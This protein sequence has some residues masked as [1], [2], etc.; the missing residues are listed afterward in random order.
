MIK[1][2]CVICMRG[3]SKG[4]KNK[5]LIKIN[6]KYLMEYTIN[7]AI[8]SK[9][10]NKIVVSSDSEKILKVVKKFKVDY[11]IKRPSKLATKNISKHKAIIQ[12]VKQ[13]EKKF[14]EK[15][16]YIFD[17]DI[18][19]PL[20]NISDIKN[21]FDLMI[22]KKSPNLITVCHSKRNPYFN[23]VEYKNNK[24]TICKKTDNKIFSRQKAPKVYD[25]NSSIY[26]WKKFFL[27]KFASTIT[28]KTA[29]YI[30]PKNRSH[31]LDEIDD[32]NIIKFY[33]KKN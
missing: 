6:K 1:K 31:D 7:N 11:I 16:D 25:M 24:L 20:R 17:L 14:N 13:T 33:L 3:N 32:I 22:K 2:I 21:S 9:F 23:M 28:P 5:N 18:C 26:I 19:S 15:Y 4:I 27:F 10:F 8:N 29:I 12:A 30:M